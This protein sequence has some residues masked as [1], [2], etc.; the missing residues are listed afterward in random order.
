MKNR[1]QRHVVEYPDG[2][3]IEGRTQFCA[4]HVGFTSVHTRPWCKTV[5]FFL[6]FVTDVAFLCV[7]S[8]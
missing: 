7:I 2:R 5:F 3:D 6:Y 8:G 4:L 1:V